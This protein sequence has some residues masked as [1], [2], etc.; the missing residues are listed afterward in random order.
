MGLRVHKQFFKDR[1]EIY[2]DLAKSGHWPTT[3]VSGQ[4]SELPLHWHD[5]DV[6]GYVVSGSTYLL[7][8]AGNHHPL[9]AGD[10]LEIPRG[11]LHAEGAV[12]DQVVY[13]VGTA[14]PGELRAQLALLSPD[15]QSRL[16]PQS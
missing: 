13:I 5:L 9:S 6:S 15:D 4:S 11:T 14:E 10:K 1:V 3:Y 2:E 12:D 8:E 7:D 16:A